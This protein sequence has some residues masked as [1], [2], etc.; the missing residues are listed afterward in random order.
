MRTH[1]GGDA[2]ST[3]AN[4]Y[5][6]ALA[7]KLGPGL[8]RRRRPRG[9]CGGAPPAYCTTHCFNGCESCC[10]NAST[11]STVGD[12]PTLGVGVWDGTTITAIEGLLLTK[13]ADDAKLAEIEA[14]FLGQLRY[15]TF[16][17]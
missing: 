7:N 10:A 5:I 17:R 2:W 11:G 3:A 4:E 9:N 8:G 15:C 12:P 1:A 14:R 13:P 6:V 16:E